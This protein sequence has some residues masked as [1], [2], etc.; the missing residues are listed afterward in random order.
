MCRPKPSRT[1][2]RP[3]PTWLFHCHR[4]DRRHRAVPKMRRQTPQLYSGEKSARA[5]PAGAMP[6]K[7]ASAQI[8]FLIAEKPSQVGCDSHR[9]R[10]AKPIIAEQKR[11]YCICAA[12]QAK[13]H[14]PEETH[15]PVPKR[16][17]AAVLHP[18]CCLAPL[19]PRPASIRRATSSKPPAR[20]KALSKSARKISTT[21]AAAC[22]ALSRLAAGDAVGPDF[23]VCE[24]QW[25][26]R[27]IPYA[28]RQ[29]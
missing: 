15:E 29:L 20:A 24:A 28:K 9:R 3:P 25:P 18:A 6:S 19:T 8:V 10:K 1:P 26:R 12:A 7:P 23:R 13:G 14:A 17:S 11:R 16:D 21:D 4:A 2:S 27:H 22:R 5:I